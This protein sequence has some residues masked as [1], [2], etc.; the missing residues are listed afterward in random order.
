M[1]I[2]YKKINTLCCVACVKE[3]YTKQIV[4]IICYDELKDKKITQTFT[5][6]CCCKL[7]HLLTYYN[8]SCMRGSR[9]AQGDHMVW[10][11]DATSDLLLSGT[12]P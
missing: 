4:V 6:N 7:L 12:V 11:I 2:Q 5:L 3:K 8:D 1:Y 10:E 9:E